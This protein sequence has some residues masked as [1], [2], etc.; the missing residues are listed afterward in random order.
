MKKILLAACALS[1]CTVGILNA[2]SLTSV[3]Y[4][5]AFPTGDVSDFIGKTSFRGINFDYHRLVQPNIGVGIS[6]GWNVFYEEKGYDTYTVDNA[7]LSGKQWRYSNHVPMFFSANYYLKPGEQINPFVGLGIGTIY[8]K[9]NTDM[10][11]YT[12]TQEAWN[13]GLQPTV[14]FLYRGSDETSIHV[15]ARYNYGF[16]AGNELQEAQSYISLNLGFTFGRM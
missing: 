9:R 16:K 1:L 8:S 11:L 15:S 6:F 2:Q 14:G 3:T 12:I 7:S 5:I 13:F 10:N 4:S